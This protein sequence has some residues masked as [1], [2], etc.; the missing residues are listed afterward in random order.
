MVIKLYVMLIHA[1]HV[2]ELLRA[3]RASPCMSRHAVQCSFSPIINTALWAL[4]GTE[5][6]CVERRFYNR[7]MFVLSQ[8][9]RCLQ[10]KM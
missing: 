10:I 1:L 8:T 9:V 2:T 4:I 6:C 5:M 3:W 7:T